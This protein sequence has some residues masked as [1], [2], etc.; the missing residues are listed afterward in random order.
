VLNDP[1]ITPPTLSVS[2]VFRYS[3]PPLSEPWPL[4][5]T[6]TRPATSPPSVYC[7]TTT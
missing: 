7:P 6:V 2:I 5:M 1:T 4:T 3:S